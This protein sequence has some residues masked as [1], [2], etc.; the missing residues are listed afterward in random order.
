MVLSKFA[1]KCT[2]YRQILWLPKCCIFF[3]FYSLNMKYDTHVSEI[4]K[5]VRVDIKRGL[6][7]SVGHGHFPE[8][9]I[10]L[11]RRWKLNAPRRA[12]LPLLFPQEGR[13]EIVKNCRKFYL[14]GVKE[15]LRVEVEGEDEKDTAYI[16]RLSL[17]CWWARLQSSQVN[18]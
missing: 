9:K 18:N 11:A 5:M 8:R 10:S 2:G 14:L 15:V 17:K 1:N 16:N 4:D 12:S 3:L 6:E 13:H 7:R